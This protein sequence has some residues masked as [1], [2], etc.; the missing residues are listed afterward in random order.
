MG[1]A[2]QHASALRAVMQKGASMPLTR[3]T[4]S[5]YDAESDT[6][7]RV[8]TATL[9]GYAVEVPGNPSTYQAM[10]LVQSEAP[11]VFWVPVTYGDVPKPGDT[12]PCRGVTMTVK[13]VTPLS[14]DGVVIAATLILAVG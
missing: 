10:G 1:Y 11:S 2:N 13:S 5:D 12:A 7:I 4:A 6:L 8:A 14:P 3:A 9:S